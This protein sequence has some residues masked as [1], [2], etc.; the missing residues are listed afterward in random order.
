MVLKAKKGTN[1]MVV[2]DTVLGES[3]L[4]NEWIN[5]TQFGSG[6]HYF[7]RFLFHAHDTI[8]YI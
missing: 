4:Q 2:A 5:V 6:A 7:H 8:V 3:V 1:I